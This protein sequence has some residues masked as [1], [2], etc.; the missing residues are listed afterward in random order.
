MPDKTYYAVPGASRRESPAE[1]KITYRELAQP[2]LEP[3]SLFERPADTDPSFQAFLPVAARF[4][5][6]IGIQC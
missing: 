2:V 4:F 6:G 3:V 1:I 5:H